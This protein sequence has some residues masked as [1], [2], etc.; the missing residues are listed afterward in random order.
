MSFSGNLI[1]TPPDS[2][3]PPFPEG[4][5][6]LGFSFLFSSESIL[7]FRPSDQFS[8]RWLCVWCLAAWTVIC[9]CVGAQ[10]LHSGFG[11]FPSACVSSLS[12]LVRVFVSVE[13]NRRTCSPAGVERAALRAERRLLQPHT[14]THTP[15]THNYRYTQWAD[16]FIRPERSSL[17]WI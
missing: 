1:F 9:V 5:R 14:H 7:R 11:R 3:S 8:V 16:D 10:M 12:P 4:F 13:R 2:S 17:Q 6:C 15:H